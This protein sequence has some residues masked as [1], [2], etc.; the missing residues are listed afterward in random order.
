MSDPTSIQ[1]PSGGAS[2]LD[3]PARRLSSL[4]RQG[5]RPKVEEF[6]AQAGVSDPDTLVSVLRVD[7]WERRTRGE[8]VKA[9]SYLDGFPMVR[10]DPER[11][12]DVIFAEYLLREQLGESPSLSEYGRRFP[13]YAGEL[14]LQVELHRAMAEE[15][16]GDWPET[17]TDRSANRGTSVEAETEPGSNDYPDIPGY[18]VLGVLGSG[19]MGMVYCAWQQKLNRTVALKILH[20]RA[21]ATSEML[22]RFR[23]EAEAVARLQHPNIVQIHEVGQHAGYP[24]LVLE[25]VDGPSLARALGGNPQPGS[26]AAELLE[27]LARAMHAAHRHGVVHRDLTP[28]NILLTGDGT[29]KI[30][31][32]GLAKLV[33]GGD[34]LRTQTGELLG[35]PSYMA[36][37]QAAGR[38]GEVGA[39]SDVYALGAILYEL[40]TGRPPFKAESPLETLRQV[41]FEEPVAP[42]RLRPRLPRDLETL[43][44]KCLRK[45]PAQRYASALALADDARRFLDGRPILARR[46]SALE[47]GWRWCRRN[48][49]VAGS[50]ASV[51]MLLVVIAV[52]SF[53]AALR[54]HQ[55]RNVVKEKLWGANLA[56]AQAGRWSGRIGR[57]HS[58]LDALAEA[59]GLGIIPERRHE[60]RDE[61]IACMTLVDVRIAR[62]WPGH[63]IGSVVSPAFDARL[64]RYVRFESAGA[65]SVRR[66][67][68]DREVFRSQLEKSDEYWADFSPDGRFL[69]VAYAAGANAHNARMWDLDQAAPATSFPP[70]LTAFGFQ[71]DG[72]EVAAALANGSIA[73]F[74]LPAVSPIR[75]WS[76]GGPVKCLAYN[77]AGGQLALA[78]HGRPEIRICDRE[79]GKVNQTLPTA[80]QVDFLSWRSDGRLLAAACGAPIQV[81]DMT[82]AKLLSVLEG[83]QNGGLRLAFNHRGDRLASSGWDGSVRLWE[84]VG[85]R[86]HLS[87]PGSFLGWGPD[88]RTLANWLGS[89]LVIYE[90]A[91]GAEY[92]T[93]PHGLVGNRAPTRS[94]FPCSVDFSPDGRLLASTS[95]DGVRIYR[96]S[97]GNEL[98][99][100]PIGFCERAVFQ[101]DGDLLTYNN[102]VGLARWPVRNRGGG[103]VRVGPPELL[104]LPSASH[105]NNR[106]VA[107][108]R[109]GKWLAVTDFG[110]GRAVLLSVADPSHWTVLRPHANIAEVAISPDGRW[111]ATGTWTGTNVKVWNTASSAIA[112]DLPGG[113]ATVEFS[114]DGRWL[115]AAH[116]DAYRFYRVG[117]W[118]PGLVVERDTAGSAVGGALAYRPDGRMLAISQMVEHEPLVQLIDPG[119]GRLIATLRAPELFA[120][121]RLAFS[122]DGTQLA[123]STLGH[124]IELWDLRLIHER[125]AGMGLDQGFP[126]EASSVRSSS[127]GAPVERLTVLGVDPKA[128]RWSRVRQLLCGFSDQ[129]AELFVRRLPD[130]V[131]YHH[132]AHRFERLGQWKLAVADLDQAV[133]G[134]PKDAHLREARAEDHL[135]LKEYAEAIEDLKA[136]LEIDAARP[137]AC[138]ALAWV[139]LTA[140]PELRDPAQ[141]LPLAQ[142]AIE[143]RPAERAFRNTL[144]LAYYRA[145]QFAKAAEALEDNV[146]SEHPGMTFDLLFLAMS[147]HR[148]GQPEA[149]RREFDR[150][151]RSQRSLDHPNAEQVAELETFRS[152]AEAVLA[153]PPGH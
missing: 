4:W 125:L 108:D 149:A 52:G 66:V 55:A 117:S 89:Q 151:L 90:V 3:D 31:D 94:N 12:I 1:S 135:L 83:H 21:Q 28:A 45:D 126:P 97:D 101:V 129:M 131:A 24:F 41:V 84:P 40:L 68:D 49:A 59:A 142:R 23:V 102:G 22:R 60:L 46:S 53:V 37:E 26:Q 10:N 106:R 111:V 85:G 99:H 119:S 20:A 118:Q 74:S 93:L 137:E 34:E 133:R 48:R 18:E 56:K 122:P 143:L 73:R 104:D 57:R 113:D 128:L 127:A 64:E 76:A 79:T 120:V 63:P 98:G 107:N 103:T 50:L 95:F 112:A 16:A 87:F 91:G 150:A 141:A 140:P 65:V 35:T 147:R 124:V 145:G 6:L 47:R 32:F 39:A 72:A 80:A 146:K 71:P 51:A 96:A 139:Y 69:V 105:P 136:A 152:E 15:G 54:L 44:L 132:R 43:C 153:R 36:P 67:A 115:V 77:P 123:A 110:N 19:G 81:W 25:R 100:F 82:E 134:L 14:K 13:Q 33:I 144:G 2:A 92:R 70:V 62:Q 130:A 42:S 109:M 78:L 11:A 88:D 7:Q 86:Q 138:N 9:E 27:T 75:Q 114:P 17:L 116:G 8:I 148:M 61:A 38:H 5:E 121:T 29:P 30:T 58:G